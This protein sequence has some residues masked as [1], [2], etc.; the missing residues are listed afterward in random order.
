MNN[1]I[2]L[3]KGYQMLLSN[4]KQYKVDKK[5]FTKKKIYICK[6]KYIKK[7]L[8]KQKSYKNRKFRRFYIRKKYKNNIL[9]K[10]Y[11]KFNLC[12]RKY[13]INIKKTNR[14][15]IF[16][17]KHRKKKKFNIK[18]IRNKY[19][20]KYYNKYRYKY[21]K[22]Q[23]N[24]YKIKKPIKKYKFKKKNL[25][26]INH[27]KYKYMS[28]DKI[29]LFN[30]DNFFYKIK[31]IYNSKKNNINKIKNNHYINNDYLYND[32]ISY[33]EYYKYNTKYLLKYILNA[34]QYF[35]KLHYLL[36]II[37]I[38]I[39]SKLRY[40]VMNYL[41]YTRYIIKKNINQ[42]HFKKNIKN[43]IKYIL[44]KINTRKKESYHT[45][46]SNEKAKYGIRFRI[47][48]IKRHIPR[49]RSI[50]KKELRTIRK[51]SNF[52]MQYLSKNQLKGIKIKGLN[53]NY[54]I[55]LNNIKT[56]LSDRFKNKFF[57]KNKYKKSNLNI[58]N[59]FNKIK[60][61]NNKKYNKKS[62][63]MIPA[64][65]KFNKNIYRYNKKNM[66]RYNKKNMYRYNKKNMYKYNRK[67]MYRYNRKNI[68]KRLYKK[69]YKYKHGKKYIY[70]RTKKYRFKRFIKNK[71]KYKYKIKKLRIIK[72]KINKFIYR[73]NNKQ[74]ELKTNISSIKKKYYYNNNIINKYN[75]Y[76]FQIR[77][78]MIISNKTLKIII[79]LVNNL[80]N[81]IINY[82]NKQLPNKLYRKW[83]IVIDS[84]LNSTNNS[85]IN[86]LVGSNIINSNISSIYKDINNKKDMYKIKKK[87][88]IGF[89]KNRNNVYNIIN[90]NNN[91]NIYNNNMYTYY[92]TYTGL[93]KNQIK[94]IN[95]NIIS[96]L[97]N[98]NINQT[99][100]KMKSKYH[101]VKTRLD[102]K[103]INS[104]IKQPFLC[105]GY[106][107][108]KKK[109]F[110]KNNMFKYNMFKYI[111]KNNTIKQCSNNILISY[112]L[113]TYKNNML[114]NK[115]NNILNIQFS[116]VNRNIRYTIYNK[117]KILHSKSIGTMNMEE[118]D[119]RKWKRKLGEYLTYW[120]RK[121]IGTNKYDYINIISKAKLRM[122]RITYQQ[123]KYYLKGRRYRI[124]KF[125]KDKK[126]K[127][128]V[129]QI[130]IM[131]RIKERIVDSIKIKHKCHN[132]KRNK[133]INKF[134]TKILNIPK[135][136]NFHLYKRPTKLLNYV[137][138][139][140]NLLFNNKKF[141]KLK[142]KLKRLKKTKKVKKIKKTKKLKNKKV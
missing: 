57:K 139:L 49:A 140:I 138:K 12:S 116:E 14:H 103:K 63:Y 133:Q 35:N 53:F 52:K 4:N 82:I 107:Y 18:N 25:Y 102:L 54:I 76:I 2:K 117:N 90:N 19:N 5:I 141:K 9:K 20:K 81:N 137:S 31:K 34:A 99:K 125:L 69:I 72:K 97:V 67:N 32:Y 44:Q 6:N 124:R 15:N 91:I 132:K 134:I 87:L 129:K 61:H 106:R 71:N 27:M 38:N 109:Y 114:F 80:D 128:N 100:Y 39:Y 17:V 121:L 105:K 120:V 101:K 73:K 92:N 111:I 131:A 30:F 96:N 7:L 37:I 122:T 55:R 59:I 84:I 8:Y 108:K 36:E 93:I 43:I 11:R 40:L 16:N 42:I 3:F 68:Y 78:N 64:K 74:K 51:I 66:Y 62:R 33:T 135:V 24:K 136:S 130:M 26:L 56:H 83:L 70:K 29:N 110:I 13:F 10:K 22:M 1:N 113:S 98:N 21:K 126:K 112:L 94:H 115:K 45:I 118:D 60:N 89:Y 86:I 85:N 77:N 88:I 104:F 123:L 50:Y 23:Y 47:R 46:I 48:K 75:N 127:F 119:R 142:K 79:N 41:K 65:S 28:L 95:K 58:N